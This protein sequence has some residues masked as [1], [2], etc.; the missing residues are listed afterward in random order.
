M[1]KTPL[2]GITSGAFD[3]LKVRDPPF[4]GNLREVADIVVGGAFDPSQLQ[5]DIASNAAALA[6]K[7]ESS[8]VYSQTAVDALVAPQATISLTTLKFS[9]IDS[10]GV[11]TL[12][13]QGDFVAI[14]DASGA[15]LLDLDAAQIT[16]TPPMN[17]LGTLNVTGQLTANNLSS[18]SVTGALA[19]KQDVLA[20]A[21]FLDATSSVQTQLN[22][23]ASTASLNSGLA[24]KQD[25]LA[26]AANLDATSSVQT[27][28]NAKASTASLNSG[29]AGKQDVLANAANLDATSSVQTQLNDKRDVSDSYSKAEMDALSLTVAPL[30]HQHLTS[31]I[32]GDT[33]SLG[34]SAPL[35]SLQRGAEVTQFY[36]DSGLSSIIHW[37]L[38]SG[39]GIYAGYKRAGGWCT[40]ITSSNNSWS[41]A[42]DARVKNILGPLDDC[43]AKLQTTT[44]CFY[45]YRADQTRKRRIGLIAQECQV[46]FPEAVAEGPGDDHMLGMCYADLVPVLL[47]A[48][49]ELTARVEALEGKTRKK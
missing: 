39:S 35:L 31:D 10:L 42:S 25:V 29:L 7:A 18:T 32:S 43:A 40:W 28:L 5:A 15:A 17:C 48:I 33:L 21:P 36:V 1:K 12:T 46:H 49:K 26:N 20:N 47:Q 27:Q 23:K 4:T 2:T 41:S 14:E 45:E 24:G 3:T 37:G 30:V 13:I 11:N 8:A 16:V 22:A 19:G 9:D 34:S 6:T 38:G 44:P